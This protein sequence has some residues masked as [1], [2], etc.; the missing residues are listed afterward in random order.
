[1][2][3]FNLGSG[4]DRF[5]VEV[6][7]SGLIISSGN[8]GYNTKKLSVKETEQ[9]VRALSKVMTI[10]DTLKKHEKEIEELLKD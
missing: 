9:F 2:I 5:R 7:E 3:I 10:I 6:T 8:E 1:M 4:H